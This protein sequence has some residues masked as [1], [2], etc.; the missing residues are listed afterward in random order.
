MESLKQ[1]YLNIQ[2]VTFLH[3][4]RKLQKT[5]RFFFLQY[6][7][8][9]LDYQPNANNK[10]KESRLSKKIRYCRGLYPHDLHESCMRAS[11]SRINFEQRASVRIYSE[12]VQK[13]LDFPIFQRSWKLRKKFCFHFHFTI[14]NVITRRLQHKDNLSLK[15]FS[16]KMQSPP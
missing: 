16:F 6:N 14:F 10:F 15:S 4:L 2:N 13:L 9:I 8:G 5:F 7:I 1:N 3:S 12:S 11:V